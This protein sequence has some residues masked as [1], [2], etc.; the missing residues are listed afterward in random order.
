MGGLCAYSTANLRVCGADIELHK[1]MSS[2][3]SELTEWKLFALP[4]YEKFISL[5]DET[6][7]RKVEDLSLIEL[8]EMVKLCNDNFASLEYL[9]D[10]RIA[11]KS[12]TDLG[13]DAYLEMAKEKGFA[14]LGFQK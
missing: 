10:Y 5:F 6:I 7:K 12:L 9:M 11:E 2:N 3:I 8:S 4:H 14:D 1:K 13:I